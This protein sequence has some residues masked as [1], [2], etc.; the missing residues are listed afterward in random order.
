MKLD[1]FISTALI[2]T[3]FMNVCV[4]IHTQIPVGTNM[5]E[6]LLMYLDVHV[7]TCG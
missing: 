3:L 5:H 1:C 4:C 7:C 6:H 2:H